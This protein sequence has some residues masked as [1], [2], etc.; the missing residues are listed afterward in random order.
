MAQRR[1]IVFKKLFGIDLVKS[2][3]IG[4]RLHYVSGKS[5]ISTIL[6]ETKPERNICFR[7]SVSGKTTFIFYCRKQSYLLKDLTA[8]LP[9]LQKNRLIRPLITR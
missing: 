4:E 7:T 6:P 1:P 9:R 2:L 3:L 5:Y 8:G